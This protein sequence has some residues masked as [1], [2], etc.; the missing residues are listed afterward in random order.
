[1][2]GKNTRQILAWKSALGRPCLY[3]QNESTRSDAGWQNKIFFLKIWWSWGLGWGDGREGDILPELASF[4]QVSVKRTAWQ[5]FSRVSSSFLLICS[6]E[7]T[8]MHGKL[9]TAS[10]RSVPRPL[11][12]LGGKRAKA[13]RQ[14]DPSKHSQNATTVTETHTWCQRKT[15]DKGKGMWT[16]QIK[17]SHEEERKKKVTNHFL[18]F[19]WT[20]TSEVELF[21]C[22]LPF[23]SW[24]PPSTLQLFSCGLLTDTQLIRA[25]GY[26]LESS[27]CGQR[28]RGLWENTVLA[29]IPP[30]WTLWQR[31]T[32]LNI[33]HKELACF[34]R[35]LF[36]PSGFNQG[37]ITPSSF[38]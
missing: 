36:M 15:L 18:P 27:G 29:Q 28:L 5:S 2:R 21:P 12:G 13:E 38:N 23:S 3:P 9:S 14:R 26:L 35:A 33:H 20:W 34:P 1:M 30:K 7:S 8:D 16:L 32:K 4:H 37:W 10:A 22:S 11:T 31:N 6:P 25:Q 19:I 24:K 17:A